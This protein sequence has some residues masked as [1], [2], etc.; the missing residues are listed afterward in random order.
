MKKIT[1][2]ELFHIHD[3]LFHKNSDLW[4]VG[5]C[6]EINND[7]KSMYGQEI[8]GFDEVVGEDSYDPIFKREMALEVI[9]KEK[10]PRLISR[11]HC[12]WLSDKDTLP[13]WIGQLPGK[14]FR[15]SATG[16]IFES[17]DSFLCG[18]EDR[19]YQEIKNDCY[20]YWEAPF[21]TETDFL[22]KEI[23]FQG[24]IKVLER[25]D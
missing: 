12:I 20:K 9:R 3:H 21:K 5:N 14:V 16:I 4:E 25:M 1:N 15:V 17:S 10:Y 13:Y 11:F 24:K 18:E 6:F 22:K 2:L 8:E 7:F 19:S 23:L